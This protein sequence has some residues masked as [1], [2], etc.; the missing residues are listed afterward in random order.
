MSVD[1]R[2]HHIEG[3]TRT[4]KVY[5]EAAGLFRH[6]ENL[7]HEAPHL[8]PDHRILVPI[9]KTV[10]I[11]LNKNPVASS[12]HTHSGTTPSLKSLDTQRIVL[13]ES[14]VVYPRH[15]QATNAARPIEY[16]RSFE[17]DRQRRSAARCH[18][19]SRAVRSRLVQR[20]TT[21]VNRIYPRYLG[22]VRCRREREISVT[23]RFGEYLHLRIDPAPPPTGRICEGPIAMNKPVHRR[24]IFRLAREAFV[25][26]YQ[27]IAK[28]FQYS[29]RIL[30]TV[31]RLDSVM[32]V[33][34][35]FA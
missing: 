6:V 22:L 29:P 15:R 16:K 14:A 9:K 11:Q 12:C 19:R 2:H 32:Q 7:S 18:A 25:V 31:R 21:F 23:A 5:S 27:P 10:G 33:D 35:N 26:L 4:R 24:G 13:C 20:M 8:G 30:S 1:G 34:L 17:N 28:F 3:L